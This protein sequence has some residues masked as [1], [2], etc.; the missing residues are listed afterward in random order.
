VNYLIVSEDT[1]TVTNVGTNSA[2][3]STT[4]VDPLLA[5]LMVGDRF[6]PVITITSTTDQSQTPVFLSHITKAMVTTKRQD[7]L[8]L[9]INL[10]ESVTGLGPSSITQYFNVIKEYLFLKGLEGTG[11]VVTLQMGSLLCQAY[12]DQIMEEPDDMTTTRDWFTGDV[13][14]KLITLTALSAG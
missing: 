7:E 1:L 12:I 14:V 13:T 2:A 10:Y 9:C 11:Q 6:Q 5:G 4:V 3:G 8:L